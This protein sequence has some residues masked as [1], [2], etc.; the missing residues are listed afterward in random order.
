M[1][2]KT[3]I[4]TK[5]LCH[6]RTRSSIETLERFKKYIKQLHLCGERNSYS[7]TDTDATFMRMKEDHMKNGQLK[8]AY[9][10]QFGVD[11]EY[12]VWVTVG[13]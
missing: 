4:Y 1:Y 6:L 7:K 11:S 3:Q 5:R 2:A 10:L 8:P 9:N 13:P 12:V